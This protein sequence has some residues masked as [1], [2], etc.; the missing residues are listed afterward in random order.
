LLFIIEAL[1][2]SRFEWIC[3]WRDV[4]GRPAGRVIPRSGRAI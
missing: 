1:Q 3:M 2:S 4:H